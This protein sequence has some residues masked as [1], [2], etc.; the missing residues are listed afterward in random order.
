MTPLDTRGL[1]SRLKT[2]ESVALI[3]TA[4]S[5]NL[6]ARRIAEECIE[7]ELPFPSAVLIAREQTE[8]KGRISRAWYSPR[9][10]GIYAT[11]LHS[12]PPAELGLM[13]LEV[14]VIVASF[15]REI[16]GIDA[17]IKWPNDILVG[18][19]K[20]AG[21]LIE[22]K[23]NEDLTSL[24]I[25]IGINVESM[26]ADAP[27]NTISIAE[28]AAGEKPVDL[29]SATEAFIEHLDAGLGKKPSAEDILS[30]WRDLSIHQKGDRISV[31]LPNSEV[32]G[33]W[34]GIDETGRAV[35]RHGDQVTHVAAGDLIIEE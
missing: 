31:C 12:R 16:Y 23:T 9:D 25:G 14:G 13:P 28:A 21:I 35:L 22:A 10:R 4:T 32:S 3:S 19:K 2:I 8:G 5:T 6:L 29:A 30:T 20:I 24:M 7:N 33:T 17:R 18:G 11:L 15:L 26:G 27:D 34:D 1:A